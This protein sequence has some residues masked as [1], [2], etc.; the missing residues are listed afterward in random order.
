MKIIR[1]NIIP[2]LGYKAVNIFGILFVR[3]NAKL[4]D[5]DINHEKIHTAQ[6]KE[7][8]YLG[9]Y[10]WYLLEWILC[11]FVSGFSGG[12]AYHDIS[13]EEEA[14]GNE[15]NLEYLETR[16]HYSWT[17]YLKLGSWKK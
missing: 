15:N 17:K 14:Y 10:L 13:F 11:L 1:N 9:Y 8:C 6:M 5:I 3:K 12:Y 2:F 7:M 16:K 4:S